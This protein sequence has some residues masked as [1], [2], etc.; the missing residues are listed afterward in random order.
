MPPVPPLPAEF[1]GL[2]LSQWMR[3]KDKEKDKVGSGTKSA[4]GTFG[5][6]KGKGGPYGV[7]VDM[8]L[9]REKIGGS[10]EED[11]SLRPVRSLSPLEINFEERR[12][13]VS[14]SFPLV[15]TFLNFWFY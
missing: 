13:N 5:R 2:S 14:I 15:N 8:D 10:E 12:F 11:V 6:K 9:D 3:R 7:R 1:G 4:P